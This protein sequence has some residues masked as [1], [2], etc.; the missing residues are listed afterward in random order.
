MAF[1]FIGLWILI[2]FVVTSDAFESLID[3][4]IYG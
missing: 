4:V 2:Y 1:L 3:R